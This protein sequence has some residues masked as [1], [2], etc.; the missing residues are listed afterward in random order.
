MLSFTRMVQLAQ[1]AGVTLVF[2]AP[3]GRVR[4]QLRQGDVVDNGRDLRIFATLDQGVEWCENH[5]LARAGITDETRDL[6]LPD[7]LQL[8]LPQAVD[9]A[10]L[11][12][13]CERLDV[14]AGTRFITLGSAA[15][16]LFF[17]ESGQVTAQIAHP[18][19][20]ALRLETSGSGSVVGEL[21]FYLEQQ[22]TADVIADTPSTL[23]R[24]TRASL[25]RMEQQSP[26]LA[27]ELHKL[28]VHLLAE[29]VVKITGGM[30]ALER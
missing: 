10:E 26:E 6:A 7:Q 1:D 23:Y 27:A 18:G 17:V 5:T 4:K 28:I 14:P 21:A 8:I 25:Q 2:T 20:A 13:Y 19:G 24:L 12:D 29:R 11:L 30:R 16:D 15:D 3:N 9:L 22:R